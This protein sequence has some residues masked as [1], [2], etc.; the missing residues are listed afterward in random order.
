MRMSQSR[1]NENTRRGTR[2][3][4]IG[5]EEEGVLF[6]NAIQNVAITGSIWQQLKPQVEIQGLTASVCR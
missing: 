1:R 5:K 4:H 2:H 6:C 3:R